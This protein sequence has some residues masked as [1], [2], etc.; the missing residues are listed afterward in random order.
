EIRELVLFTSH[1]V[2]RDP[3]FSRLNLISC[4]NLLIYLNRETQQKVLELF[5]FA[6]I[7]KSFLFLGSSE[8][9]ENST[10]LFSTFD[11]K[12]R[13]YSSKVRLVASSSLTTFPTA[14]RWQI[15]LPDTIKA[16]PLQSLRLGE[17]HLN[18]IEQYSP[19]SILINEEQEIVHLSENAGSYLHFSGGEPTRDLLKAINPAMRLDLRATIFTAKQENR[20]AETRNVQLTIDGKDETVDII[21]RPV[22]APQAV[23]GYF[24]V[25]FKTTENKSV[26]L[27][28][29]ENKSSLRTS[30]NVVLFFEEELQLTKDRLRATIEQ[31]ETSIEELKASNEE[32]QAINEELRS[33]TEELETS[34][35]ESQSVNEELITVNN[36]LK[37]KVDE[38]SRANSD[39]QNLITST[40]IGTMFLD[41]R[42]SIKR[43]TPRITNIFNVIPSDVGRPFEHL[44]HKLDYKNISKDINQVLKTLQTIEREV[45]QYD[46]DRWYLLRIAPYQAVEFQIDG[47]VLTFVDITQR[48]RAET[49]NHES[50]QRF[51]VIVNQAT[52]GITQTDLKS[53]LTFVNNRFCEIVGWSREEII[54]KKEQSITFVN[55]LPADQKLFE[56]MFKTGKPYTNEKR[57]NR[58]DNSFVWVTNSVSPIYDSQKKAI[59]ALIV[60][61]D[62]S[63]SKKAEA[64]LRD[65]KERMRLAME[66]A[67][68][69]LWEVDL[70]TKTVKWSENAAP[71]LGFERLP[72][73]LKSVI[74]LIHPDDRETLLKSLEQAE[75]GNKGFSIEFR[76]INPANETVWVQKQG[77]TLETDENSLVRQIG[78]AQN[79]TPRRQ[80]EDKLKDVDKRKDEFLAIL[81]HELRNPLAPI[82]TALEVLQNDAETGQREFARSVIE[83]QI[84]QL[85]NLVDDLLD[86]SRIN[87]GKVKLKIKQIDLSNAII[88][89]I[90]ANSPLI[91]A[92]GHKLRFDSPET[93]IFVDADSMR[94]TQIFLN[95]LNN[96][97]KYTG[98][99]GEITITSESENDEAVVRIKDNGVGIAPEKLM[100]I[101]DMFAQIENGDKRSQSGLGIG[102][103][104]V[105]Q[106]V[107]MH[108]GTVEAKSEGENKGSEFIVRLPLSNRQNE[109]MP[110]TDDDIRKKLKVKSVTA[111]KK[112][113]LIVD[114]NV[115]AA[116]M[117]TM[118]FS[119][120]GYETRVAFDGLNAVKSAQE[121]LPEVV[122]LDIGLPDID[123]YETARR[124]RAQLNDV[125]L[126]ALSGWGQEEDRRK[127][128]E[129]GFNHH[130]VKPVQIEAI[131]N[132]IVNI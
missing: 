5:N 51:N 85:V 20:Q 30:E 38:V 44:T 112:R 7:P 40:D 119:L 4:R 55:D 53:N 6:L 50:Q 18:L 21:V 35:E 42:L 48:R 25:I 17:I 83:R 52:T 97:A 1:N 9:A 47:I 82:R 23:A 122:L 127:S 129:A 124:I 115:D 28:D 125:T 69:Y 36:E 54:G 15:E 114:D 59:A 26:R 73:N 65:Q 123:G 93:P 76:F 132:I 2:L 113:I 118:M 13:I 89:A 77:A 91:K 120:E 92:S 86:V 60:T 90:E 78:I 34:K 68:L 81:A 62:I 128:Q 61:L 107:E 111:V 31:Y 103:S 33:T 12:Q 87:N 106:L 84:G 117:L 41:R 95:I 58:K 71:V 116:E 104:L 108:A 126:I 100:L 63:E 96:A 29:N 70:K 22:D 67:N 14:G 130:L 80:A 88:A 46:N 57:Y 98:P 8:S 94:L 24:L 66:A 99:N 64:S 102:L 131:T 101:F 105:K 109:I 74:E 121:F 49:D 39:L 75:L 110:E 16:T 11:K 37:D 43:F 79:I 72:E 19:P 45:Y 3:P 32:L 10:P 27:K 56:Q